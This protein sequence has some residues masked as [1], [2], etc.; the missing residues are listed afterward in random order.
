PY[1]IQLGGVGDLVFVPGVMGRLLAAVSYLPIDPPGQC[2]RGGLTGLAESHDG[3]ATWSNPVVASVAS[4]AVDPA[5]AARVY[6]L[7]LGQKTQILR[8][9][10][11]GTTTTPLPDLP[12]VE[13]PGGRD[14]L[15][16]DASTT[17]STLFVRDPGYPGQ[18]PGAIYRATPGAA[19]NGAAPFWT[20]AVTGLPA[21]AAITDLILDPAATGRL[22]AA[23]DTGVFVSNDRGDSWTSLGLGS[24]PAVSALALDPGTP[25]GPLYA[26]TS[27]GLYVLDRGECTSTGVASCLN[28]SRFQIKVSFPRAD[29][30][31]GAGHSLPLTGDS[32]AFW[33]FAPE[34]L[35]LVVKLLD[36]RAVNGSFWVFSGGLSDVGYTLR[37]TDTATGRVR[38]YPNPAG[39]LS[40]FADTSAFPTSGSA[41]GR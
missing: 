27:Q 10:D 30:T 26:A 1:A 18:I 32:A 31:L 38:T 6:L 4:V 37:I 39:R 24:P 41:A 34:N 17:P 23:T 22:Y 12:R 21:N 9:E 7:V 20:L 36:G 11:G 2:L 16:V 3:G 28:A 19:G 14:T 8:S 29:G 25:G 33:F 15:L 40:S 5:N 35:E 13:A